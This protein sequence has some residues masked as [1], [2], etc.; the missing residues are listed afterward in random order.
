[1]LP[2]YCTALPQTERQR[3]VCVAKNHPLFF[4]SR[5]FVSGTETSKISLTYSSST[6]SIVMSNH[7]AGSPAIT[8]YWIPG[9]GKWRNMM[10]RSHLLC[11]ISHIELH[12][13]VCS[14]PFI[15]SFLLPCPVPLPHFLFTQEILWSHF[16]IRYL[17]WKTRIHSTVQSSPWT[18]TKKKFTRVFFILRR[19]ICKWLAK[20]KSRT[21]CSPNE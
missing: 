12:I 15:P 11:F 4:L 2:A 3:T 20:I 16:F 7:L 13:F 19:R 10:Q 14:P 17:H 8:F 18:L 9:I 6:H 21:S 5:Y 1:M